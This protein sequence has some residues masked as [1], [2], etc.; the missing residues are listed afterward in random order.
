M[1]SKSGNTLCQIWAG[2][3]HCV[4]MTSNHFSVGGGIRFVTFRLRIG[5]ISVRVT[6]TWCASWLT[7]IEYKFL[8]DIGKIS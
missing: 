2:A 4:Y 3:A 1:L 5:E 8:K 6:L 7:L